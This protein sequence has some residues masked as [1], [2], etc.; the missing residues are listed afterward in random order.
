MLRN[1]TIQVQ[2]EQVDMIELKKEGEMEFT[3]RTAGPEDKCRYFRI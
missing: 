2:W 3:R 1:V